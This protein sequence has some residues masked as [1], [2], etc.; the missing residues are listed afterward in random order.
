MVTDSLERLLIS[1]LFSYLYIY[2]YEGNNFWYYLLIY[3]HT[4]MF[5]SSCYVHKENTTLIYVNTKVY[6]NL[7]SQVCSLWENEKNAHNQKQE[8]KGFRG[9]VPPSTGFQTLKIQRIAFLGCY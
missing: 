6:H 7:W 2:I 4:W 9:N 1:V 8:N 5:C 3:A